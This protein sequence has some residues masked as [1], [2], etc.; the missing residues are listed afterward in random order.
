M[1]GPAARAELPRRLPGIDVLRALAA[2]MV[3]LAHVLMWPWAYAGD[4]GVIGKIWRFLALAV[5]PWGVG[6]FFVLSGTCIHL[7]VARR[8]AQGMPP[9][10]DLGSYFRRRFQRIYPPHLLVIFIAWATAAVV[11]MPPWYETA[12][13]YVSVPTPGQF[14]AHLFM[15]HTF[16][17]G[18]RTSICNVLWTIALEA[19]FYLLYPLLLK[20]RTR[21]R[22]EILC[23]VLFAVMLGVRLLDRL[24]PAGLAGLLAFNFLGRW[25]EWVLGAVIAERLV[26]TSR[27]WTP[28]WVAI[29]LPLASVVGVCALVTLPHGILISTVCSPLLYGLVVFVV[30]RMAS[31]GPWSV[32][33]GLE[34]VGV[35]SYSLYLTHPIAMTLVG[36]LTAVGWPAWGQVTL[37]LVTSYCFGWVYFV[38]VESRF[39][40]PPRPVTPSGAPALGA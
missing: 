15:V 9:S 22:M 19:H 33:R 30:A 8:L 29:G 39:L 10:L 24:Y 7:P 34:W 16:V 26:G 13:H 38:T 2:S 11:T 17:P 20:L 25:W 14:V 31:P 12:E 32:S 4:P 1:N 36:S 23:A 6:I 28:R 37:G 40:S 21:V 3:V 27:G 5:G 18:A 35:R